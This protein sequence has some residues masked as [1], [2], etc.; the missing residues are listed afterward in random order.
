MSCFQIF[1]FACK[2]P[3]SI[4]ICSFKGANVMMEVKTLEAQAQ[5]GSSKEFGVHPRRGLLTDLCGVIGCLELRNG[6]ETITPS[7]SKW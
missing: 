2:V 7:S 3:G 6:F 1:A 5:Q 4:E